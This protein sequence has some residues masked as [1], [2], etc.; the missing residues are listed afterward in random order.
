M[1]AELKSTFETL[2]APGQM[3]EIGEVDVGGQTV[4]AWKH[5]PNSLRDLWAMSA[6]HGD[7]DYLVYQDERWTYTRAHDEVARIAHW[8]VANGVGQHDRTHILQ[9][10]PAQG[11]IKGRKQLVRGVYGAVGETV[12]Q[13]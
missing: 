3:F 12:E 6:G 7:K 2:T 11:G 9:L 4:K 10:Q 5:A 1:Y 13:C 8:L